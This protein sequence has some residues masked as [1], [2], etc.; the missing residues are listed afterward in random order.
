MVPILRTK[1]AVPSVLEV[2][3]IVISRRLPIQSRHRQIPDDPRIPV[4]F[5]F[6]SL[7]ARRR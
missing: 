2:A 5:V 1:N 3:G 7:S 6:P 4:G